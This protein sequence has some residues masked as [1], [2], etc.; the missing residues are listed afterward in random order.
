MGDKYYLFCVDV[1][2][3]IGLSN[4]IATA[5]DICHKMPKS[6][7]HLSHRVPG[8]PGI[9]RFKN[10]PKNRFRCV[11]FTSQT[12]RPGV[13]IAIGKLLPALQSPPTVEECKKIEDD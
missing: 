6:W 4:A 12:V 10:I 7:L 11:T 2:E 9:F 5:R 8:E 13:K 3:R 1:D